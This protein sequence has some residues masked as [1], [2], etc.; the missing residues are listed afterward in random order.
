MG[1]PTK[2]KLNGT[3]WESPS[4]RRCTVLYL[5]G[6]DRWMLLAAPYDAANHDGTAMIPS[7]RATDEPGVFRDVFTYE[8]VQNELKAWENIP[9]KLAL[10]PIPTT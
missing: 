7:S 1:F 9:M 4:Y 8:Q 10:V 6:G 3:A 2:D 5:C